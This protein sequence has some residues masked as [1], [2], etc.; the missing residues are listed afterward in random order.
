VVERL[1]K[2]ARG[3]ADRQEQREGDDGAMRSARAA[4]GELGNH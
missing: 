4:R 1:R 3:A 2:E